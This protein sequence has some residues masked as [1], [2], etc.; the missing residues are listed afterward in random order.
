MLRAEAPPLVEKPFDLFAHV[1]KSANLWVLSKHNEQVLSEMLMLKHEAY[2]TA[3]LIGSVNSGQSTLS[4]SF[5]L[6][7]FFSLHCWLVRLL[8][9]ACWALCP[10][11]LKPFSDDVSLYIFQHQNRRGYG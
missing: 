3:I 2:C 6:F 11:V 10:D 8:R 9:S 5:Y 7:T 1:V 4:S